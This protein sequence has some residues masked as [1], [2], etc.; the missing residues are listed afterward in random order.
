MVIVWIFPSSGALISKTI[1]VEYIWFFQFFSIYVI[2]FPS[3]LQIAFPIFPILLRPESMIRSS[4]ALDLI[5]TFRF[6]CNLCGE[7]TVNVTWYCFSTHPVIVSVYL[8]L[9]PLIQWTSGVY[10]KSRQITHIR[11][12]CTLIYYFCRLS[13]YVFGLSQSLKHVC[14]CEIIINFVLCSCL[15]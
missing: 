1:N 12:L 4:C 11:V 2:F 7:C 8:L 6:E 10:F 3:R 13:K 5:K 15:L 9:Q 14:F